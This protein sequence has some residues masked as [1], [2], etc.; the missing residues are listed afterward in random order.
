MYTPVS[1]R[2]SARSCRACEAGHRRFILDLS[3]AAGSP[4]VAWRAGSFLQLAYIGDD[5]LPTGFA[6]EIDEHP[7]PAN[8]AGRVC[9]EFVEVVVVPSDVCILHRR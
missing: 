9:E 8:E 3:V 1:L 2:P 4:S 6:R 5:I 7:G